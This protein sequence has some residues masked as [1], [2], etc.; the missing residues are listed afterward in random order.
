MSARAEIRKILEEHRASKQGSIEKVYNILKAAQGDIRNQI[1]SASA[2][3]SGV[4][5]LNQQIDALNQQIDAL[6]VKLKTA[7]LSGL[8]ESWDGGA[9]L[10][11]H[12]LSV[13]GE[14]SVGGFSISTNTL[15][16]LKDFTSSKITNITSALQSKIESEV[17]LGTLGSQTPHQV[18]KRIGESLKDPSI[19]K[20]TYERA[21]VITNTEMGRVYA[22]S[23]HRNLE[24]AV[25]VVPGLKKQWLHDGYPKVPRK[26]HLL[27]HEEVSEVSESFNI[28]GVMMKFPRDPEAPIGEIIGCTCNH[29]PWKAEWFQ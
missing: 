9:R 19:F 2:S 10:V 14:V 21:K 26:S 6:A 17:I 18:A 13:A 22:I 25:K 12:P 8:Q 16:V 1:L 5:F 15:E 20:N 7:A 11:T 28:G 29:V 24:K 27:A 3:D 23:T 4:F